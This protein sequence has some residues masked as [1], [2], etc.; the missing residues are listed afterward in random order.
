MTIFLNQTLCI[1]EDA[2]SP[3]AIPGFLFIA[4]FFPFYFTPGPGYMSEFLLEVYLGL[5]TRMQTFQ[6]LVMYLTFNNHWLKCK[7]CIPHSG[8]Q[9]TNYLTDNERMAN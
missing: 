9:H 5:V 2:R 8:I 6:F 4:P 1:A 3:N 7:F